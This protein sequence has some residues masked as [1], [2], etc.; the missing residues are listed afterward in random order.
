MGLL[1]KNPGLSESSHPNRFARCRG[2]GRKGD[3]SWD[4]QEL[5][6]GER[7]QQHEQRHGGLKQES[8]FRNQFPGMPGWLSGL[9]PAFSPGCDP[10]D[11]R[12][13][14]TSGSLHGTCF[15]LCLCCVSAPLSVCV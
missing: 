7:L 8:L 3:L 1:W 10:G 9:A 14:P 4:V 13:S 11:P 12:S 2:A 15:S 6:D 5:G